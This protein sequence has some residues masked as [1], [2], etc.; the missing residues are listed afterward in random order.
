MLHNTWLLLLLLP[1]RSVPATMVL[2]AASL[3]MLASDDP[4][5]AILKES[6]GWYHNF[7]ELKELSRNEL[8]M[9]H[10]KFM[11]QKAKHEQ[12]ITK[13]RMKLYG[14]SVALADARTRM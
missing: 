11:A 6:I 12:K 14:V 10:L 4:S 1:L 7:D 3:A 8:R 13:Q 9:E 5:C 2:V